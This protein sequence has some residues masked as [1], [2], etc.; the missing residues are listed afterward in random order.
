M[1]LVG[2]SGKM[3]LE[4]LAILEQMP[5]VKS[6]L[7]I[8]RDFSE[9][10]KNKNK[11]DMVIDFSTAEAFPKLLK[12]ME[13][14]DKP[15]VSGTTGLTEKDFLQLKKLAKRTSVFWAPNMSVGVAFVNHLVD[16]LN[17]IKNF[18]FQIIE[19]HHK[20]KKDKP[21]GT[22]KFLQT[23]LDKS[24][25]K[26]NPEAL[27]V[28]GGGIFGLHQIYAMSDEEVIKIEHSALSRKVFAQGA[29][30]VGLWLVNQKPGLYSMGDYLKNLGV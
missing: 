21:S 3:G 23:T 7:K 10:K 5:Q 6:I 15:F 28:R 1:A 13:D 20:H 2:A 22:A 29:V 30:S 16:Q 24:T 12:V 27:A 4:I 8:G 19:F 25:G 26:K 11:I 18:D 9:L 14:L 17:K